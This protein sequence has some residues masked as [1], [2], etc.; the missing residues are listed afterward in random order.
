MS[1]WYQANIIYF[2][3][4]DRGRL[5]KN[6]E[7]YLVD[8]VSYTDAEARIYEIIQ[9]S[10]P[11]FQLKKLAKVQYNEVFKAETEVDTWFRIKVNF[12]SF[13][14]KSQKEKL[15]S[16]TFLLNTTDIASAV[17][18]ITEKLGTVEDYHVVEVSQTNIFEVHF[19]K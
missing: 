6:T 17:R 19:S 10:N 16:Y 1:T 8:S 15:I 7:V 18:L 9:G 5:I 4:D 12:V 13:D 2:S 3:Q 11:D 14:E